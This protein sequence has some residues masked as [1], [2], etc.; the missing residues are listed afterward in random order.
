MYFQM[1]LLK[2]FNES[3]KIMHIKGTSESIKIIWDETR[4]CLWLVTNHTWK[5][6]LEIMLLDVA[7]CKTQFTFTTTPTAGM[8]NDG[9][10]EIPVEKSS[11]EQT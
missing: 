4:C 8:K 10:T 7:C 9:S 5:I 6:A 3:H 2:T 1:V 11:L